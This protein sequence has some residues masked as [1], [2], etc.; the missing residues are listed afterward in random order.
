MI[1]YTI[2][3]YDTDGESELLHTAAQTVHHT[4]LGALFTETVT[5]ME[6]A[7]FMLASAG[8]SLQGQEL[9]FSPFLELKRLCPRVIS[10]LLTY[11]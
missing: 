1:I 6:P 3:H 7:G 4:I 9:P 5:C 2:L 10:E 11:T 8:I